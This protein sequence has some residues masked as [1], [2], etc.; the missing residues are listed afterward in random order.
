MIWRGYVPVNIV[1]SFCFLKL[2]P[3][4]TRDSS[5]IFRKTEAFGYVS[6]YVFASIIKKRLNLDRSLYTILQILSV[7]L[8]EKVPILQTFT[9]FEYKEE[10][11]VFYKQL[12][13]FY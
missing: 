8:F 5:G 10:P 6:V 3:V 4:N 1:K 9:N 13:L 12:P 7:T 2:D 11:C